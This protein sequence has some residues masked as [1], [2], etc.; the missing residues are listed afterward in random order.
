MQIRKVGVKI[1]GGSEE[2][3]GTLS[4][5]GPSCLQYWR[6]YFLIAG[7]VLQGMGQGSQE[8]FL[9]SLWVLK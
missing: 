4:I 1:K 7:H 5:T 6:F 9:S 8:A 3:E 2:A